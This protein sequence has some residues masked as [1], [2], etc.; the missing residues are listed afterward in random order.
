VPKFV[1]DS[2]ETTGLKWVAPAPAGKVLQVV[3]VTYDT[4]A[5]SSSTTYADTGLTASITPSASNSKV[6]VIIN[7]TWNTPSNTNRIGIK[8]FRASTEISAAGEY[9]GY[10]FGGG[11]G[12]G[13]H[14]TLTYLDSPNTT[15]STAYKTQFNNA[16]NSG[17][18]RVNYLGMR[19]YITLMEI[20]A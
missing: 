13:G 1:A 5:S 11:E 6:L 17:T 9:Y 3:N 7:Q 18:V 16:G 4:S 19:S 20:G 2:V 12:L 8:L 10:S 15:S 14:I